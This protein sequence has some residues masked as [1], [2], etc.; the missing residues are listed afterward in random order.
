MYRSIPIPTALA[1]AAL[2]L[3][4]SGACGS[5]APERKPA[6]SPSEGLRLGERPPGYEPGMYPVGGGAREPQDG[7]VVEHTRGA[8][9]QRDVDRVLERHAR[10]LVAC[11]ER[12]GGAQR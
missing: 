11:Y 6:P 8:L 1:A 9:E 4:V 5:D 10:S 2:G 12:A 7:L 3:L